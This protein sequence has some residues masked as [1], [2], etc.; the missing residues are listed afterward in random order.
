MIGKASQTPPSADGLAQAGKL[1]G[2]AA[3]YRLR[4]HP[5]LPPHTRSRLQAHPPPSRHTSRPATHHILPTPPA[6]ARPPCTTLAPQAPP[7]PAEA[8]RGRSGAAGLRG[9]E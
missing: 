3:R 5:L 1:L 9:H 7:R 2:A 8:G 6:R 4:L